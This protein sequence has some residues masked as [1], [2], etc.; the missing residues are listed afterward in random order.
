MRVSWSLLLRKL[1]R[2]YCSYGF[3]NYQFLIK[4]LINNKNVK[5]ANKVLQQSPPSQFLYCLNCLPRLD[6]WPLCTI[7]LLLWLLI[8]LFIFMGVLKGLNS[9]LFLSPLPADDFI[10]DSRPPVLFSLTGLLFFDR[11]A[12]ISGFLTP[13]RSRWRLKKTSYACFSC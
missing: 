7:E 2:N 11:T 8:C 12:L 6:T 4:V 3:N 13:Q 5:E 1:P 9:F 10:K